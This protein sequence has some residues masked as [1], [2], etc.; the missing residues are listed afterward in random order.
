MGGAAPR[1][2]LCPAGDILK[3]NHPVRPRRLTSTQGERHIANYDVTK[4][5][6]GMEKLLA[7]GIH[8]Q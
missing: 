1:S 2:G 8:E 5:N 6:L 4:M 7:V 3:L